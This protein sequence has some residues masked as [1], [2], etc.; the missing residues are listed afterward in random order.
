[1][2]RRKQGGR[3]INISSVS[4]LAGQGGQT[5][6][7]A[8]KAGIIGFT[9]SLA[10]ELG[11]RQVTVNAVAPGFFPTSLTDVLSQDLVDKALD[12]I[13]LKRIGE[14]DEV[15]HLVAF[16]ASDRASYTTGATFDASGGMLMR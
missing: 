4:G 9:K 6:Y 12:L 11:P 8:S 16:L 2:I 5:N 14:L 7:A 3:I 15:A 1:M 13:P 10:K